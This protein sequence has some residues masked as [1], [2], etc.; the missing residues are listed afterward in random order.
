MKNIKL[1]VIIFTLLFISGCDFFTVDPEC[2]GDECN[3]VDC[4]VT[5]DD[6]TCEEELPPLTAVEVLQKADELLE[7]KEFYSNFIS[8]EYYLDEDHLNNTTAKLT[9]DLSDG[10]M[11]VEMVIDQLA[12]TSYNF[13]RTYV[14]WM[15]DDFVDIY[16]IDY[17][18]ANTNIPLDDEDNEFEMQFSDDVTMEQK[19]IDTYSY[20]VISTTFDS[21]DSL[22]DFALSMNAYYILNHINETFFKSDYNLVDIDIYIHEDT[23]EYAYID[24]DFVEVTNNHRELLGFELL[25]DL[26][27]K[28]EFSFDENKVLLP[29][30]YDESLYPVYS[31][32]VNETT[33]F[34]YDLF[35]LGIDVDQVISTTNGFCIVNKER[36]IVY[37]LDLLEG[38]MKALSFDLDVQTIDYQDGYLFVGLRNETTKTGEVKVY[39]LEYLDEIL[40]FETE[41]FIFDIAVDDQ[42]TVFVNSEDNEQDYT[43]VYSVEGIK[44]GSYYG[45]RG[46]T[47]SYHN[48]T[49]TLY[50]YDAWNN[51]R[52]YTI[53]D[54]EYNIDTTTH[55]DQFE[56]F[57]VPQYG[58]IEFVGEYVLDMYGGLYH[59]SSEY[60]LL[61][62]QIGEIYEVNK[63]GSNYYVYAEKGL[64]VYEEDFSTINK[65]YRSDLTGIAVNSIG[66]VTVGVVT[67]GS[68]YF[69]IRYYEEESCDELGEVTSCSNYLIEDA[70]LPQPNVS[71]EVTT[72]LEELSNLVSSDKVFKI[73]KLEEGIYEVIYEGSVDTKTYAY[74]EIDNGGHILSYKID[75]VT[76]KDSY[77]LYTMTESQ[78]FYYNV[79]ASSTCEYFV[80]AAYYTCINTDLTPYDIDHFDYYNVLN[81]EHFLA[82]SD[83]FE[84]LMMQYTFSLGKIGEEYYIIEFLVEDNSFHGEPAMYIHH[85]TYSVLELHSSGE[86]YLC[87]Y[88]IEEDKEECN[89]VFASKL[90]FNT[91]HYFEGTDELTTMYLSLYEDW[92]YKYTY[93]IDLTVVIVDGE[94]LITFDLINSIDPTTD[95]DSSDASSIIRGLFSSIYH[96]TINEEICNEY[97][98]IESNIYD[99]C[100]SNNFTNITY[101]IK[102]LSLRSIDKINENTFIFEEVVANEF[103][104]FYEVSYVFED[105]KWKINTYDHYVGYDV[106]ILD[107]EHKIIEVFDEI[108]S[109][110][111]YEYCQKHYGYSWNDIPNQ[112]RIDLLY[113]RLDG[114][115]MDFESIT[116]IEDNHFEITYYIRD[117][118]EIKYVSS[119]IAVFYNMYYELSFVITSTEVIAST[120]NQIVD[121]Y[122]EYIQA[123]FSDMS[124]ETLYN[125]YINSHYDYDEFI[126]HVTDMRTNYSSITLQDITVKVDYRYQIYYDI[127]YTLIDKN[128]VET[129][130]IV[131][132]RNEDYT[133]ITPLSSSVRYNISFDEI[134]LFVEDLVDAMFIMY[135]V[136]FECSDFVSSTSTFDCDPNNNNLMLNEGSWAQEFTTIS[137]NGSTYVVE[138]LNIYDSTSYNVIYEVVIEN[139]I[140]KLVNLYKE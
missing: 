12:H 31:P 7:E 32:T 2:E 22:K 73:T 126:L 29:T 116:L 43:G 111:D 87:N 122:N 76:V 98:S 52:R 53:F 74:V 125:T 81:N 78:E 105:G 71:I 36:N 55:R 86:D 39:L 42:L 114:T 13:E 60:P 3:H 45:E 88:V 100:I 84:G 47:M 21:Y 4:T 63:T 90:Q 62:L 113:L 135:F 58:E 96:N 41:E 97:I 101:M 132:L 70:V 83:G 24:F 25:R 33:D 61:S 44:Y 35:D 85:L 109:Y 102:L 131:S 137:S 123:L 138:Y 140:I 34:E 5:P 49:N 72:M 93:E 1:I 121:M 69:F 9:Y 112:C 80:G 51:L 16:D 117:M 54:E 8:Y 14:L 57:R 134:D 127:T 65:F 20:Y 103:Q 27:V 6:I 68:D 106:S 130:H 75:T 56:W 107:A 17:N 23:N 139:G 115:R 118:N 10:D 91:D 28:I 108:M 67:N 77:E 129:N 64:F 38:D 136:P 66:E 128:L 46:T 95:I 92:D 59:Y 82:I 124:I 19:T 99:D 110:N 40:S 48:E 79:V 11:K 119:E 89:S 94:A 30:K 133:K 26:N 37:Y 50:Y 104:E 18:I 120:S 15:R